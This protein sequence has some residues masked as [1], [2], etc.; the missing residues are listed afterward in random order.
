MIKV[1]KKKLSEV[2]IGECILL[3]PDETAPTFGTV[4]VLGIQKEG[5]NIV[6]D[7]DGNE[8]LRG[9]PEEIVNVITM[10]EE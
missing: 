7:G 1:E 9:E 8:F 10:E 6:I 3:I 5:D 4:N 2:K